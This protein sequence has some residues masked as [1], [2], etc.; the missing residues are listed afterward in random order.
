MQSSAWYG[1][2]EDMRVNIRNALLNNLGS[3]DQADKSFMKDMCLC[4]STI[5]VVEIPEGK[6]PDFVS[7]MTT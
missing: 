5:A 3:N 7:M 4:I 1:L 6:W 2:A